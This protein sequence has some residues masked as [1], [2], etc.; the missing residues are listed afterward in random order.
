[1]MKFRLPLLL[2]AT[3]LLSSCTQLLYTNYTPISAQMEGL[4]ENLTPTEDPATGLYGYLGNLG[5][6]VIKPQFKSASDF[7]NGMARVRVGSR[8][9]AI[10]P[11]G[12]WVIPPVFPSQLDCDSAMSSIRKGRLPGIE[13]WLTEDPETERYGFLNHFGEWHIPPQYEDG[14]DFD[15]NGFAVVKP[16]NGRWGVIN[17]QNQWVIQ[18]NFEWKHEAQSALQRLKR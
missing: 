5:L 3:T 11:L 13:L 9:G 2:I 15:S 12:Q 18:P 17:R 7:S 14:S 6:W 8:Y 4:S 1:M 10:N 16:V